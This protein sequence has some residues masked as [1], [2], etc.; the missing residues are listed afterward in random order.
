VDYQPGRFAKLAGTDLGR[1]LWEFIIR[2]EMLHAME[3]ASDL[4]QPAVAGIEE[5]LLQKFGEAVLADRIK[6][7]IGH[8]VR[9][10]M[11]Q[12]GFVVD[13]HDVKL[14][15][16]PFAKATR[17][18]RPDWYTLHVFRNSADSRELCF[19]QSRSGEKLPTTPGLGKWRYWN[20]FSTTLRGAVAFGVDPRELREE[21]KRQGYARRRLERALRTAS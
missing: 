14:N 9:Q 5:A 11:E 1:D 12:T 16:I 21:V 18:R 6:Q 4:G 19:T 10:V 20:T 3:V 7:M 17:Y 2:S 8:M 15:S 13:Q